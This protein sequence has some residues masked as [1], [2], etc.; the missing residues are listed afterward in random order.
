MTERVDTFLATQKEHNEIFRNHIQKLH[1]ESAENNKAVSVLAA[2]HKTEAGLIST[3]CSV[4]TA[5]VVAKFS[6]KV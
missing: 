2:K 6:G 3:A 4:V 1:S 5:Y